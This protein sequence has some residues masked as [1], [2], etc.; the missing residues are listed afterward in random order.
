MDVDEYRYVHV[1]DRAWVSV[2]I[3]SRDG[4]AG[5]CQGTYDDI[6]YHYRFLVPVLEVSLFFVESSLWDKP[7]Y[8]CITDA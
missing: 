6:R 3:D 5:G 8:Y 2:Y 4:R 1:R 7:T